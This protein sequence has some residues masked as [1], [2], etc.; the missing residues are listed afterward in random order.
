M[1]IKTVEENVF[2]R[3]WQFLRSVCLWLYSHFKGIL[4]ENR[5]FFNVLVHSFTLI[6]MAWIDKILPQ[7]RQGSLPY[8]VDKL[9]MMTWRHR[10]LGH[11]QPEYRRDSPGIFRPHRKKGQDWELWCRHLYI[12]CYFIT[13]QWWTIDID[14]DKDSATNTTTFVDPNHYLGYKCQLTNT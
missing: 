4:S 3:Q 2:F 7:G 13:V 9:L 10:E 14:L 12:V 5:E 8:I 1:K 11:Q 6:A